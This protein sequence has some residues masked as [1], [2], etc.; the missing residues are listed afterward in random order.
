[1][2]TITKR[3]RDALLRVVKE[4]FELLA[5]EMT[6]RENALRVEVEA[7]IEAENKEK[8]DHYRDI[9]QK[10]R[11]EEDDLRRRIEDT[12]VEAQKNGVDIIMPYQNLSGAKVQP[13]KML[14]EVAKRVNEIKIAH[15]LA[16]GSLMSLRLDLTEELLVMGL[17]SGQAA[18]FMKK[19][20]QIDDLLPLPNTRKPELSK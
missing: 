18:E 20:P 9:I 2:A 1:M 8:L 19:I 3:D 5:Y 10:L 4:R 6:R 12:R 11:H 15:G 13:E 7:E 16:N 14:A 17:E